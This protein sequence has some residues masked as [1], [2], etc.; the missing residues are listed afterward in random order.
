[1]RRPHRRPHGR[2]RDRGRGRGQ[3][4]RGESSAAR[5]RIR[6]SP[7]CR[8]VD[9]SD[10]FPARAVQPESRRIDVR[11]E[12]G[13]RALEEEPALRIGSDLGCRRVRLYE[14]DRAHTRR[15]HTS[16]VKFIELLRAT[17]R[18]DEELR[19]SEREETILEAGTGHGPALVFEHA[20]LTVDR[21]GSRD[22]NQVTVAEPKG[23][24][25]LP[26]G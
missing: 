3:P 17:A 8:E 26:R 7:G 13:I 18:A 9:R 1:S 16:D 12:V 5:W 21:L 2:A 6:A 23:P 11:L 19:L 24:E 20:A 22:A 14:N 25:L 10:E 4:S 15:D